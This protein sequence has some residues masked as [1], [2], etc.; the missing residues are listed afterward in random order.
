MQN[1]IVMA[2]ERVGIQTGRTA[3]RILGSDTAISVRAAEWQGHLARL[4]MWIGLANFISRDSVFTE[5]TKQRVASVWKQWRGWKHENADNRLQAAEIEAALTMNHFYKGG[6]REVDQ[7]IHLVREALDAIV[8]E[9]ASA[10]SPAADPD[11]AFAAELPAP[12]T[13]PVISLKRKCTSQ[14]RR[15][16]KQMGLPVSEE[17]VIEFGAYG[18]FLAS[19]KA[20]ELFKIRR[21]RKCERLFYASRSDKWTCSPKCKAAYRQ[22]EWRKNRK[23]YEANRQRSKKEGISELNTLNAAVRLGEQIGKKNQREPVFPE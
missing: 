6:E 23:R 13:R 22:Q 2:P 17:N 12:P 1:D 4:E 3:Q 9:F 8:N 15:R 21:C 19:L 7:L 16:A 20:V 11:E 14:E 18:R 5:P 10:Q